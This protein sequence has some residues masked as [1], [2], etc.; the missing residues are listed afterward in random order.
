MDLVIVNKQK[1]VHYILPIII[2]FS[3]IIL[4]YAKIQETALP[5]LLPLFIVSFYSGYLYLTCFLTAIIGISIINQDTFTIVV[6]IT[7]LLTIYLLNFTHLLK[8]KYISFI[9]T[10]ILIP[11]FYANHYNILQTTVLVMLTLFNCYLDQEIIPLI[12]HQN[13]NVLN[14]KRLQALIVVVCTLFIS[15]IPFNTTYTMIF[16]RYFLLI[17]IY[18]LSIEKVMPIILYLSILLMLIAPSLKDDVLSLIL[19]MSFFFMMQPK[20]KYLFIS[21]FLLSHITLPFFINY[22]YFYYAFVILVPVFL[23]MISPQFKN[24]KINETIMTLPSD[25]YEFTKEELMIILELLLEFF[26]EQESHLEFAIENMIIN[27]NSEEYD[28]L[29]DELEKELRRIKMSIQGYPYEEKVEKMK[30]IKEYL[31]SQRLEIDKTIMDN[32]ILPK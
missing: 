8:T 13:K 20:N 5:F 9:I 32:L 6:I 31:R 11:F 28:Y 22:N 27:L 14:I 17:S 4:S 10:A 2:F 30:E 26:R 7:L 12:I 3:T 19:P 24:K 15:F 21:I 1:H 23:F 29:L 25:K 16:L 18:Y